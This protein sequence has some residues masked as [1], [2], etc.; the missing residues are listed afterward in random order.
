MFVLEC[1]TLNFYSTHGSLTKGKAFNILTRK[2]K[3]LYIPLV[4]I[5]K[6][7]HVHIKEK[8]KF[9]EILS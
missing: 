5:Y 2:N 1:F 7:I 9:T 8:G 3:V 6:N 4:P